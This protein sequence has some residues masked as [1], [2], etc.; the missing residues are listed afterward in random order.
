MKKTY[1]CPHNKIDVW[2]KE[3][4][5][6]CRRCRSLIY[7]VDDKEWIELRI[8]KAFAKDNKKGYEELK[9]YSK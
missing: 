3:I 6:Y 7:P 2:G 8:A 1:Q 9:K 5:V 4:E